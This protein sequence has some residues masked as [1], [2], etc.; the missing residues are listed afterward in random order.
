MFQIFTGLSAEANHGSKRQIIKSKRATT[1]GAFL[2]GDS[3]TRFVPATATTGSAQK[4]VRVLSGCKAQL[5]F[6]Y[7]VCVCSLGNNE[8][9]FTS[10]TVVL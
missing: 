2:K 4:P 6:E 8:T 3:Q 7:T 1:A 5:V 10:Y 9:G